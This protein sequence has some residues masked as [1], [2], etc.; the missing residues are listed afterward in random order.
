MEIPKAF[1]INLPD[2]TDRLDAFK[3]NFKGWNLDLE[4]MPGIKDPEG[5]KG[6]S[7]SH[8]KVIEKAKA[9]GLDWVLVL[10][11]DCKPVEPTAERFNALLPILWARRDEWDIFIGGPTSTSHEEIRLIQR[12]PPLV[13]M[14]GFALQFI[15]VNG[16]IFDQILKEV[17]DASPPVI[18]IYYREKFRLWAT[19]PSIAIQIPSKSNIQG[20]PTNYRGMFKN[21]E[22]RIKN[23]LNGKITSTKGGRYSRRNKTRLLKRKSK[24][25]FKR[26][27]RG[28]NNPDKC[29]FIHLQGGLGNQLY[30][31]AAALSLT[32]KNGLP[33]CIGTVINNAH[34]N[35][36]YSKILNINNISDTPDIVKRVE[37]A[38]NIINPENKFYSGW[39][40]S[41][42]LDSKSKDKK[43]PAFGYYQNYKSISKVLPEIKDMLYKKAF[44]KYKNMHTINSDISAFM[45][46]RRGDYVDLGK[47]EDDQYYIKALRELEKN[48]KITQIYILSNDIEW[49]KTQESVWK[50]HTTKQ[51]EYKDIPDELEALYFMSQC[52]GGAIIP[53]STFSSWGAFL[54]A[55]MN[56]H[57]TIIYPKNNVFNSNVKKINPNDFP[58]RWI[59]I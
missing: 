32:K 56:Q 12:D 59:G 53:S 18:D 42:I 19:Y 44:N 21:A 58:A 47:L 49:C 51:I 28:G 3:E 33:V 6:C 11:D 15:I 22:S 25:V 38:D 31:Y 13:E 4:I 55:D 52:T 57:S 27:Q 23:I 48:K 10:E 37:L 16:K 50:T 41:D 20:G 7:R 2:R 26:N 29:L 14:K 5:W 1:V 34:S 54:G 43:L 30:I 24:R 36:D 17:D 45:H 46:V 35:T 39:S 9:E 8:R 40:N